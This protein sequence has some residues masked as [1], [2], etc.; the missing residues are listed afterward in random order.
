M[1][2]VKVIILLPNVAQYGQNI[3]SSTHETWLEHC[4]MLK[5]KLLNISEET[6]QHF[7]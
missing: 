1:F 4:D 7:I 2:L 5:L 6:F 3:C